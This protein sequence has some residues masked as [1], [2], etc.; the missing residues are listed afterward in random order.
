MEY[1][2]ALTKIEV[3]STTLSF[4]TAQKLADYTDEITADLTYNKASENVSGLAYSSFASKGLSLSLIN[5]Q[6]LTHNINDYFGTAGDNWKIRVTST[7]NSSVYG[8]LLITVNAI[9][10]TNISVTSSSTELEE[11]EKVQLSVAVTPNNA[12]NQNV[13]WSSSYEGVATVDSSGL[14]TAVSSSIHNGQ[15]TITATAVDGSAVFGTIDITVTPKTVSP[16]EGSYSLLSGSLEVGSYVIFASTDDNGSAYACGGQSSNVRSAVE[17][18]IANSKIEKTAASN[19]R[20]FLVGEGKTSGTYSFYDTVE[21]AYLCSVT[22]GSNNNIGTQATL[23]ENGSWSVSGTASASITAQ[24]S[25]TKNSLRY[26]YNNGNPRFSC[27]GSTSQLARPAIFVKA[28]QVVYPSSL[29]VT[30]SSSSIAVGGTTQLTVGYTPTSTTYKDVTY[31]S[32]NTSVATVS[33]TGLVTGVGNGT[34]TITVTGYD[35]TKNITATIDITVSYVYVTGVSIT[36]SSTE[37]SVGG[38]LSLNATVSPA[39]ATNKNV[40]WSSSNTSVATVSSTGVVTAKAAGETTITVTTV[41]TKSD[42]TSHASSTLAIHV[43]SS[44]GGSAGNTDVIDNSET[45]TY[46]GSK[47]TN[48]WNDFTLTGASGCVYTVHSMGLG[49]GSHALQWNTNG[50]LYTSTACDMNITSITVNSGKALGIGLSNSVIS[51]K[52]GD[53]TTTLTSGTYT[54]TG[55]YKYVRIWGTT[56]G[57]TVNSIS[58]TYASPEPVNPTSIKISPDTVNIAKGK[59]KSLTVTY[60][61]STANTNLE[62]TWTSSSSTIT[63]DANGKVSVPSTATVGQTATI[64]AKL[65][66]LPTI[67][68]TRLVTVVEDTAPAKTIMIYLC[69][70]DL[71]SGYNSKTGQYSADD[72]SQATLNI[73]EILSVSG[74]SDDVNIILETG[75]TKRWWNSYGMNTNCL[76]RWHVE[77]QQLVRDETLTRANMAASSTFQSFLEWGLQYY[78]A[79]QTGVIVWDHGNGMQGCCSDEYNSSWDMLTTGEVR[80]ALTNAYSNKNVTDKLEWIGYDCCLMA[81]QDIASINADFFNYQ[82]SSQESEPGAGWDYDGWIDPLFKNPSITTVNLLKKICDTYKTKVRETYDYYATLGSQYQWYASFDDTTLAIFDLAYMDAYV[83]AWENMTSNLSITSSSKFNTIAN[84]AK[85]CYAFANTNENTGYG[86]GTS[87]VDAYDAYT[88]L[89]L[90]KS[91]YSSAGASS[92]QTAFNNVVIYK[93]IGSTYQNHAYGMSMFMAIYGQTDNSEEYSANATKLTNWRSVN[94]SYGKWY[95]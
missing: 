76:E 41:G 63:V 40:T 2:V 58:I 92:V 10:V 74:Q 51:E 1:V 39:N 20:A 6:G 29:S 26:N 67:T 71:E 9:P 52:T 37:V 68:A 70:S 43:T 23:A 48:A 89:S 93:V 83:T 7:S 90:I 57:I 15:T 69:G 49:G 3:K 62:V 87:S 64:T 36:S 46:I 44:G 16:D 34:A 65:T 79:Q 21:E 73:G 13:T 14:V 88:F 82:I 17:V 25:Y 60:T 24:G 86:T 77:N 75:G 35:G 80:T 22:S 50:Y 8:E 12:T 81:M 11:G 42:G 4:T 5:P 78:P 91:N 94:V 61:P 84:Y 66:N 27:Y 53:E 55:A 33:N 32:S 28:G 54:P 85:Q 47:A 30:T 59:S 31:S 38:T 72:G 18:T 45:S 56:S 19:F 95:S